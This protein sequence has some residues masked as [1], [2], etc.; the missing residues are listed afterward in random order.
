MSDLR[1]ML[2][3]P[4]TPVSYGK[5]Y[6]ATGHYTLVQWHGTK[7]NP[8]DEERPT[9]SIATMTGTDSKEFR[10]RISGFLWD[11][12]LRLGP[13]GTARAV[14]D[15]GFAN[16]HDYTASPTPTGPAFEHQLVGAGAQGSDGWWT[17]ARAGHTE[18]SGEWQI[19]VALNYHTSH[20]G[21]IVYTEAH[22]EG[23]G[24]ACAATGSIVFTDG[25]EVTGYAYLGEVPDEDVFEA[26]PDVDEPPTV[27][28]LEVKLIWPDEREAII[29][30]WYRDKY[31][32][33]GEHIFGTLT[34]RPSQWWPYTVPGVGDVWDRYTGAQL[35][36]RHAPWALIDTPEPL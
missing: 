23:I 11:C 1:H 25:Y 7:P 27:N 34:L 35:R 2:R 21:S 36:E 19:A 31:H 8:P 28:G 33:E 22:P 32:P 3:Q 15:D 14:D 12:A 29:G 18:E 13:T 6:D 24:G 16:W 4:L 30:P 5:L 10:W 20:H 17:R 26:I 9:G